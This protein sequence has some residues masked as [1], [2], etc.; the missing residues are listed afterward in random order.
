[1]SKHFQLDKKVVDLRHGKKCSFWSSA[2]FFSCAARKMRD[3]ILEENFECYTIWWE[4]YFPDN[5]RE[6]RYP[7]DYEEIKRFRYG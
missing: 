1:M 6:C 4:Q 3:S 5:S 7:E 2:E